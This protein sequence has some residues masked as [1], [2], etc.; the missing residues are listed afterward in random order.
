MLPVSDPRQQDLVEVAEHGREALAR[1]GRRLREGLP[2]FPGLDLS[3][4]RQF[5]DALEVGRR[6]LERRGAVLAER[7][8]S[9]FLI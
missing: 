2:D 6:P 4:D 5:T 9:S 1:L 7:H 3:Q 8:P